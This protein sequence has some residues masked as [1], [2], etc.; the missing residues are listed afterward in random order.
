[1]QHVNSATGIT[2]CNSHTGFGAKFYGSDS[3]DHAVSLVRDGWDAGTAAITK[4]ISDVKGQEVYEA[5]SYKWDVVGELFDIGAVLSGEPE[6]WLQ[7]EQNQV[8]RLIKIAVSTDYSG[9]ITEQQIINR[10]AAIV[11][12]VDALQG[13]PANIV[14][15]TC[16]AWSKNV[17]P[18]GTVE[19]M[20]HFGMS[21]LP[22][23]DITFAMAHPSMLR[24]FYFAC[25]EIENKN[26]DAS[27][28]PGN[29][30]PAEQAE[31]SLYMPCLRSWNGLEEL[32]T[33]EGSARWVERQVARLTAAPTYEDDTA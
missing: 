25:W 15:L 17:P 33:P 18:L 19:S 14:E 22:M 10:G 26:N 24:R 3:W 28:S 27:G 9:S 5:I 6:C 1:M 23:N 13:D 4:K 16:G 12:L 8:K 31:Y 32:D 2:Y 11:A 21:P 30:D 29:M 20:I 7:P